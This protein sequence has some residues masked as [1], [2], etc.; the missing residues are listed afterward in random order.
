MRLYALRRHAG[1]RWKTNLPQINWRLLV[2]GLLF[3]AVIILALM[4]V[5][6]ITRSAVLNDRAV[7]AEIKRTQAEANLA[8]C[9]NG[10]ALTTDGGMVM[11]S[12][13]HWVEIGNRG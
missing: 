10:N 6:Y 13:A 3:A 8:H 7:I 1:L 5:D 2:D 11:C 9:L 4:L 12:K